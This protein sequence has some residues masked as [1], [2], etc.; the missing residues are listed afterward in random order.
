MP[1]SGQG[2]SSCDRNDCMG[3]VVLHFQMVNESLCLI[4]RNKKDGGHVTSKC[5]GERKKGEDEGRQGTG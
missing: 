2:T 4:R 3:E 1:L 5:R